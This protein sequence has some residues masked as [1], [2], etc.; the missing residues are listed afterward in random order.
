DNFNVDYVE[1][2]LGEGTG[3]IDDCRWPVIVI[4]EGE[5]IGKIGIYPSSEY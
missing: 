3:T 2:L 5:A 1:T 4:P